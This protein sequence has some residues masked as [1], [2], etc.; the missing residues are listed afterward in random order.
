MGKSVAWVN[1]ETCPDT[2]K[3]LLPWLY[4][5]LETFPLPSNG[6]SCSSPGCFQSKYSAT[7]LKNPRS[8]SL[9]DTCL[10]ILTKSLLKCHGPVCH[11]RSQAC[12]GCPSGHCSDFC[13]CTARKTLLKS[14]MFFKPLFLLPLKLLWGSSDLGYPCETPIDLPFGM[15]RQFRAVPYI[16]VLCLG[17]CFALK[18]PY[19]WYLGMTL[20]A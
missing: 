18:E 2:F 15:C 11:R 12:W 6:Y 14:G 1:M 3:L 8:G 13:I 4:Y 9:S 7:W 5:L 19:R 20:K 10:T 16:G 17:W